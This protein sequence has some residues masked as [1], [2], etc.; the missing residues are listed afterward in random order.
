MTATREILC[1]NCRESAAQ[2]PVTVRWGVR[3]VRCAGC[4]LVFANPQ[5]SET[6]LESYYGREYFEKNADKF[7]HF[8]LPPEVALRFRRYLGELRAVCPQGRVLDVGCGTGRFLWVAREASFEVQGVELSPYAAA[9]GREKLG[10]PIRTG[11]L[12]EL[13]LSPD[14]AP[15]FEAITMWDFLEHT[16][17]PLAVLRAARSLLAEDGHLLMTVPNVGSW[18]ARGM[19]ERWF[20]FDKASEHLFYFTRESLRRL[21]LGAGFEPLRV[22]PH[23]WVCTAGFLAE[24]GGKAWSAGG[25][26]LGGTLKGLGL[27]EAVVRFPS[28]NLLAVARKARP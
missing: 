17:E 22:R 5:P 26:V 21:L 4:G 25:R 13:D 24:R 27:A 18:W 2:R 28:V 20:G 11:R 9:L 7:L 15:C 8:P 23:A 3:I 16:P 1:P 10:V 12:E 14:P 19:G 6:E